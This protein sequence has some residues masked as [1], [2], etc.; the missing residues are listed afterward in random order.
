[1]GFIGESVKVTTDQQ[2]GETS[3]V[4]KNEF[5]C[6]HINIIFPCIVL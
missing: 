5:E 3:E 1:M 2:E 6:T 4:G